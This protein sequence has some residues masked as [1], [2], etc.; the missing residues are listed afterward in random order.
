MRARLAYVVL[1]S[2]FDPRDLL[3]YALGVS[4]AYG[5]EW[6]ARRSMA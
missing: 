3:A 2:D 4:A 1:G 6:S 5:A